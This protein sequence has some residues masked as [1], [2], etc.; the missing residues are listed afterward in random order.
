MAFCGFFDVLI[1]GGCFRA[2]LGHFCRCFIAFIEEIWQISKFSLI[3]N[4]VSQIF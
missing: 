1:I 4:F 2:I 3:K